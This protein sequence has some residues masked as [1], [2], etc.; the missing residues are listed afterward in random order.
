MILNIR[1]KKRIFP[2]DPRGPLHGIDLALEGKIPG[3]SGTLLGLD[4]KP[5]LLDFNLWKSM[6]SVD[7]ILT[8]C[9][10]ANIQ[11]FRPKRSALPTSA[12]FAWVKKVI[13]VPIFPFETV[14]RWSQLI[15]QSRGM[16]S[17]IESHSRISLR[18][19]LVG[20]LLPVGYKTVKDEANFSAELD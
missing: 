18:L 9:C 19:A 14:C 7:I 10:K 5:N 17:S 16:P 8:G 6:K 11:I 20:L 15:A 3:G 1:V 13:R 12:I 2:V 4:C